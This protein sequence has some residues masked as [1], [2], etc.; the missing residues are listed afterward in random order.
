MG[1]GLRAEQ[2]LSDARFPTDVRSQK[3][4]VLRALRCSTRGFTR[5]GLAVAA[6]DEVMQMIKSMRAGRVAEH[7]AS[8]FKLVDHRGSD[9]RLETGDL[10]DS[11][12]QAVP[13]PAPAWNWQPVQAYSWD[14]SQHINVLELTAVLN[15]IR[16]A[17]KE[18]DWSELRFFHVVDSR[19]CSCV[20]A[21][22]RSS[23]RALNRLL[24]RI[25]AVCVAC[26]LY[27]LPIW[28]LSAWNFAD[29]PSRAF[30]PA[31]ATKAND[32]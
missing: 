2:S 23:S 31:K 30:A 6:V 5:P 20:L 21:K 32:G 9:V 1:N 28:T 19:V 8:L 4:W 13:Y 17:V 29:I 3:L 10:L 14:N 12:R 15:F 16:M 11:S 18:Y 7:L 24:R 26:D 25:T 27:L 22:G